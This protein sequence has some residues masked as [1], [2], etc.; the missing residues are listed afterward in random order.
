MIIE[1]K[2]S[3]PKQIL[4]LLSKVQRLD[5][6]YVPGKIDSVNTHFAV[7]LGDIDPIVPRGRGS[8]PGDHGGHGISP[9]P[10]SELRYEISRK[11]EPC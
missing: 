7:C 6:F 9:L 8:A 2:V 5:N 4:S 11:K 1:N 3:Y 10:C